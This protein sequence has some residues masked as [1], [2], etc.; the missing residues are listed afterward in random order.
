MK[1]GSKLKNSTF[2][3]NLKKRLASEEPEWHPTTFEE[4]KK[5]YEEMFLENKVTR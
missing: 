1:T 5:I 2:K 3:I 4:S